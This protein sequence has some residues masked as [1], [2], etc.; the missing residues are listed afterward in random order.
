MIYR[1][2][3]KPEW[4]DY[5]GH[6]RDAFYMLIYSLATDAFMDRIGLD[7][8][9]RRAR[10]RTLYTLEAHIG[11][12]REIKEGAAVRVEVR[13]IAH[14]KKRVHL[15]MEMF[16]G[17]EG[18][19]GE[20]VSACEQMMLHIDSSGAPKSASFDEDIAARIAAEPRV[21]AKDARY[22]G[23]VIG[24]PARASTAAPA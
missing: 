18:N 10:A 2:T 9:G 12:L 24:L 13:V 14:D 15:Y 11:Y 19:E 8:A 6:L 1:D 5:N 23:R 22:A 3:V 16:E 21:A 7:D 4:V 17:D 20:P